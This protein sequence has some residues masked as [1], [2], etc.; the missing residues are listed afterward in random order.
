MGW[1]LV[2]AIGL[3]IVA[4]IVAGRLL[5]RTVVMEYQLGLLYKDGRFKRV[6]QPGRHWT[7][8]PTTAITRIDVR[9]K[10]VN[11]TGQEVA[12]AD[13][14]SL[15]LSLACRYRIADPALAIHGSEDYQQ[16]LYQLLQLSL[17][18]IVSASNADDLL[19]RRAVLGEQLLTSTAEAG[20]K[21]GLEVESVNLKD[22]T[23]PGDLK[24][25]FAQV[26]QAQKEGQAALERARSESAALR[27]LANAA[28]LV[29]DNPALMQLRL[30]QQLAASSGNTIL[31]GVPPASSPIPIDTTGARRPRTKE[32]PEAPGGHMEPE[33]P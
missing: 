13:G 10:I 25:I 14:V 11:V 24:K 31:L 26:V 19:Q 22:L 4:A 20:R 21:F 5:S 1:W 30:L 29:R 33:T 15:K 12:T 27:N 9:P 6:L 8:R 18:E 32:L 28:N 2:A 23:F 7:F 3:A 16:A 17:R